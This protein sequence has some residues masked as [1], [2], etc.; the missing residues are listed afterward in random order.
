[1]PPKPP[2]PIPC[3]RCSIPL[4]PG[5]PRYVMTLRMTS[6]FDGYLPEP[7]PGETAH[8]LLAQLQAADA[9]DLEAEVDLKRVY[10]VCPSCRVVILSNPLQRVGGEGPSGALQ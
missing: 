2:P 9:E 7:P 8:T 10:T 6:D 3:D 4:T 5:A 1:M